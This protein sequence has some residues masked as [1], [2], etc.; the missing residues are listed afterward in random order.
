MRITINSTN[1]PLT[2]EDFPII[3]FCNL[4]MVSRLKM[5]KE[6][7]TVGDIKTMTDAKQLSPSCKELVAFCGI[8][9]KPCLN[10][11]KDILTD[12]GWCC[13]LDVSDIHFSMED[14]GTVPLV[15]EFQGKEFSQTGS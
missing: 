10:E 5:K 6:N 3:T 1:T 15:G 11:I 4:N 12:V 2:M 8:R 13:Q 7:K 9:G 14:Y